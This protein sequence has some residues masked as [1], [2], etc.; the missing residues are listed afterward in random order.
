[1]CDK[2]GCAHFILI[3]A[4]VRGQQCTAMAF[5]THYTLYGWLVMRDTRITLLTD[6]VG[7]P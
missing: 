7:D 3:T 6:Y 1:M 2:I 5:H 4:Y